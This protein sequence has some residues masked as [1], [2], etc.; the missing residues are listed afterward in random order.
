[1]LDICQSGHDYIRVGKKRFEIFEDYERLLNFGKTNKFVKTW[2][3]G[4]EK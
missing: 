1:M 4:Q 3:V 2:L